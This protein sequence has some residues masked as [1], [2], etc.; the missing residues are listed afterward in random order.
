[1]IV[2]APGTPEP[3]QSLAGSAYVYSGKDGTTIWRFDGVA[4]G[5]RLGLSV[6]GAGDV[7]GDLILD[8][9]VG[10]DGGPAG[11]RSAFVDVYKPTLV[12]RGTGLAGSYNQIP[13][14]HTGGRIPRVGNSD[15]RIELR[16]GRWNSPC[17]L[18]G[19][20]VSANTPLAGLTLY[21][22]FLT[23]GAFVTWGF[24]TTA[25]GGFA[26][27]PIRIPNDPA[28]TGFKTYRGRANRSDHRVVFNGPRWFRDVGNRNHGCAP[29]R[30]VIG[31]Q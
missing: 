9:I 30:D 28:L 23:P 20:P 14:I 2:G 29:R 17:P 25:F 31:P 8:V 3:S 12:E 19:S 22:D 4:P 26:S 1:M 7:N 11:T 18:A 21:G 27:L 15:F 10:K 13:I 24:V 5:D 6:A 16:Y